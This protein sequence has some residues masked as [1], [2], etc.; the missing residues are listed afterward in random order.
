MNDAAS[1]ISRIRMDVTIADVRALGSDPAGSHLFAAVRG[2]AYVRASAVLEAFVKA[3]LG[4]VLDEIDDRG[5]PLTSLRYPLHAVHQSGHFDAL[6]VVRGVKMWRKRL[7]LFHELDSA[8]T[9]VFASP[10]FAL[11]GRTLRAEHFDTIWAVFGFPRDSLPGS[12]QRLALHDLAERR[13]D[14]AHGVVTP[15]AVARV[16]P[17]PDVLRMLRF[18]EDIV[19]HLLSASKKYL[20]ACL[21]RR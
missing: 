19:E 3:D 18:V 21:Y 4:A 2:L 15:G 12:L 7:E 14:I 5:T 17:T 11:D 20:D 1:E 6:K 8:T 13:N 10:S 9:A 16:K